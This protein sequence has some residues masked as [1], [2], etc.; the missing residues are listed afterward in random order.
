MTYEEKRELN[1]V[2]YAAK[3]KRVQDIGLLVGE[4]KASVTD[5]NPNGDFKYGGI[6]ALVSGEHVKI[7]QGVLFY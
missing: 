7:E 1:S 4:F 2:F 6:I 5:L 3:T